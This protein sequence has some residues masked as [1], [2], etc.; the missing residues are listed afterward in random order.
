MRDLFGHR[1]ARPLRGRAALWN[2]GQRDA[3]PAQAAAGP[4]PPLKLDLDDGA[5]L[6]AIRRAGPAGLAIGEKGLTVSRAIRLD[7]VGAARI[8][9]VRQRVC[10]PATSGAVTP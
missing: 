10:L 1:A 5:V 8:D 9:A 2:A 4:P 3:V 6:A 7:L